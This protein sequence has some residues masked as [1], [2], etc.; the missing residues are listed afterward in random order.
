MPQGILLRS[1]EGKMGRIF[2]A[3][4]VVLLTFP[5]VGHALEIMKFD[6]MDTQDQSD[7]LD[8]LIRGTEQALIDEMHLD[9]AKKQH[10]LFS[11]SAGVTTS[12]GMR[13]LASELARARIADR[14]A[15]VDDPKLPR[16]QIETA[17]MAVLR[18]HDIEPPKQL[19]AIGQGFQPK[20]P[21]RTN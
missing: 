6:M 16:A 11:S 8:L 19:A 18:K 15:M 5:G 17:F 9:L 12:P 14:L 4:L 13:D 3:A 2:T 20:L 21:L 1:S 10:A 7:Y